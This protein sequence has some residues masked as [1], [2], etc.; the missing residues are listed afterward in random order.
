MKTRQTL[1]VG[2]ERFRI[3]PWH[4]SR[5]TAYLAVPP[6]VP[7]PTAEGLRRCL[8][9]IADAGYSSIITS[10]L[11]PHEAASF[12]AVGFEE[13]DRLVVLSHSLANIDPPRPTL[14]DD[15]RLRRARHRDRDA[16]LVVDGRAFKTFWRLDGPG[17]HE[18]ETATPISRFRVAE[19]DGRVVGYA[20]TGRAGGQGFLQRL[21]TDPRSAGMG[22]GSALTVD[23]LRWCARRRARRV[24]VNTQG[25]NTRAIE[26]YRRLGFTM[27]RGDLVV[28][29]RPVP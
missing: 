24:L 25:E 2:D 3:G 1:T 6:D 29:S 12:L 28:L 13:Y 4:A 9:N 10:A 23:A 7:R 5:E 11:H 21:A 22:V 14:P 20:V 15:V 27:T 18:A 19:V 17:L 8:T 16:A 26:L